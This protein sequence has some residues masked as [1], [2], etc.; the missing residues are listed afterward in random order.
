MSLSEDDFFQEEEIT[1]EIIDL[2][3][4]DGEICPPNFFEDDDG[5][6][7]LDFENND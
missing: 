7:E 1:K 2:L 5:L 6:K 3:D 4:E